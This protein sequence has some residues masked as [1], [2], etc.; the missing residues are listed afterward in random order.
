MIT[1]C[2]LIL[3]HT[4]KYIERSA[5]VFSRDLTVVSFLLR[6]RP[7]LPYGQLHENVVGSWLAQSPSAL[8]RTPEDSAD[9]GGTG[10]KS[11]VIGGSF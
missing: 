5:V 1:T 10:R 11:T 6:K 3:A 4:I 9:P 2:F 8:S 7:P